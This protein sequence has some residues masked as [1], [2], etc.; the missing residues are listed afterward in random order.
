MLCYTPY[1][2]GKKPTKHT[3]AHSP[4]L[5]IAKFK[6]ANVLA[7]FL[8][9]SRN[10]PLFARIMIGSALVNSIQNATILRHR[11]TAFN[12]N[13]YGLGVQGHN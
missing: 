4:G 13:T 6:C 3:D 10:V 11:G 9:R 8:W 1:G 5:L 2:T 7:A 12:S